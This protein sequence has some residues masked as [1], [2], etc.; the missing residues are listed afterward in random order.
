MKVWIVMLIFKFLRWYFTGRTVRHMTILEGQKLHRDSGKVMG[1]VIRRN[2][3]GFPVDM[4]MF[5]SRPGAS[6][7]DLKRFSVLSL[8]LERSIGWVFYD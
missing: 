1:G 3:V 8:R 4:E 2:A 5:L 7:T 6:P